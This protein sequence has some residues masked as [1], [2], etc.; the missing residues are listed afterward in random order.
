[1]AQR[2]VVSG[3][4]AGGNHPPFENRT[5]ERGD[6]LYADGCASFEALSSTKQNELQTFTALH[7]A[8]RPYSPEGFYGSRGNERAMRILPSESA[9]AVQEHPLIRTHPETGRKVL[10][11]NPVYTVGIKGMSEQ[12]AAPLLKELCEFSTQD[13]FI[14]RHRWS[15]DMLIMWDNR[16]VQHAAQGGYDGHRRV[17]HRTTVRGDAPTLMS[18]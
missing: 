8:R 3:G 15:T 4:P 11:V 6:T 9:Y 10:W 17:M 14:Y 2:L 12:E 13:R 16:S 7:S 18:R 5:S 1:M